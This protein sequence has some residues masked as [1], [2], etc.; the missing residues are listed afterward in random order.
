M[1]GPRWWLVVGCR[2]SLLFGSQGEIDGNTSDLSVES[3]SGS[4]F[5]ALAL[6][7]HENWAKPAARTA[8]TLEVTVARGYVEGLTSRIDGTLSSPW[9]TTPA[10]IKKT[11]TAL[12]V[13]SNVPHSKNIHPVSFPWCWIRMM[14]LRVEHVNAAIAA[15]IKFSDG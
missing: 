14:M 9:S 10:V 5:V 3:D 6:C 1:T 11:A 15:L 12:T 2:E 8:G 13:T 7:T 4:P